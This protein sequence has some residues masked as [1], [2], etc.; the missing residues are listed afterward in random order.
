MLSGVE[1]AF[2]K[3]MGPQASPSKLKRFFLLNFSCVLLFS[4]VVTNPPGI[5]ALKA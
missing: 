4:P 1:R 2:A 5:W 3:A